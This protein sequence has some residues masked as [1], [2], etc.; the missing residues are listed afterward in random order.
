M[1]RWQTS[2]YDLRAPE[3][4]AVAVPAR[5]P[6]RRLLGWTRRGHSSGAIVEKDK[7]LA[8]AESS[9]LALSPA[10][11]RTAAAGRSISWFGESPTRA[12]CGRPTRLALDPVCAEELAGIA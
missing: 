11:I 8:S 4:L 12:L 10:R 3:F 1:P 6:R 7:D 5:G 9:S 2:T